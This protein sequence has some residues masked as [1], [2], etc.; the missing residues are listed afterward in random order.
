MRIRVILDTQKQMAKANACP[1]E[2]LA[3][4]KS[5]KTGRTEKGQAM[6]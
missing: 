2:E 4:T 6:I 5:I 1:K 3:S